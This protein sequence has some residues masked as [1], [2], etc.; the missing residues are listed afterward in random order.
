MRMGIVQGDEA[1]GTRRIQLFPGPGDDHRRN[2]HGES[3]AA[4]VRDL[5]HCLGQ[6]ALGLNLG[7]VFIVLEADGSRLAALVF[8]GV[9]EPPTRRPAYVTLVIEVIQVTFY[10][11]VLLLALPFEWQRPSERVPPAF[12]FLLLAALLIAAPAFAGYR[13]VPL[14]NAAGPGS[15]TGNPSRGVAKSCCLRGYVQ[16]RNERRFRAAV[17]VP[18]HIARPR[19]HHLFPALWPDSCVQSE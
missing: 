2:H 11:A 8:P 4:G 7:L 19:S 18:G 6:A 5:W 17:E 10:L 15:F 12:T 9:L 13:G 14:S 1:G 3:A 16:S